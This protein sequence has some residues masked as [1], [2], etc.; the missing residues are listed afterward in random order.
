MQ[1]GFDQLDLVKDASA[2][3]RLVSIQSW[4]PTQIILWF[5]VSILFIISNT[6]GAEFLIIVCSELQSQGKKI[7]EIQGRKN[8]IEKVFLAHWVMPEPSEF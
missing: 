2:C 6:A 5:Y 7:W 8:R 1:S 3:G 4:I